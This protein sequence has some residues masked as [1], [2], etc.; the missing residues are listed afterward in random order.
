[1]DT[2]ILTLITELLRHLFI[3]TDTNI[4]NGRIVPEPTNPNTT[5]P[6]S[7]TITNPGTT[8]IPT[9][10]VNKSCKRKLSFTDCL[11]VKKLKYG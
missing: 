10:S 8:T 5:T 3:D 11:P 1:M 4:W 9:D 2:D 6:A 7:T